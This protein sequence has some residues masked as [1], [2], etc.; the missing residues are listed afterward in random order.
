[1][2]Q[3]VIGI[4]LGGTAIKS[5]IVSRDR[6]VLAKNSC[7][8]NAQNGPDAVL[9]TI[10][11]A[12]QKLIDDAQLSPENVLAIGVGS[13]GPLNWQTGIVYEASNLPG[14]D[15][16]PLVKEIEN[17]TGLTTFLEN[18][19]N[20]ACYGEFWLGAG[21]G[22]QNMAV[23]TLG[24][25]IGG[26]I[27]IDGKLLRGLDGT[28]VEFG[29]L[30]MQRDGRQCGCGAHGCLETYASVTGMIHTAT[31]GLDAGTKSTLTELSQGDHNN[32][33]GKMIALAAEAGDPFA[34]HVFK[35]TAT[36]LGLGIASIIN[37]QNP[38][39]IILC[40]GM[41]A[42]GDLLLNPT[43]K[44]AMKNAFTVP[45]KRCQILPAGLGEDAGVIGAAGCALDRC[46]P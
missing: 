23:F 24:T 2:S 19:A 29:H 7:P 1:M 26:G 39:R 10:A 6:E 22:T 13:P 35:E 5:A 14:W 42:A 44:V 20:A 9:D 16:V 27:V 3:V 25:G 43:R 31:E 36:W 4:D 12:A 33:T 18:D 32:L 37:L 40:G 46:N 15:N 41:I 38:E 28:A 45:A 30:I 8:T 11:E 21:Q 34:Q 17:R